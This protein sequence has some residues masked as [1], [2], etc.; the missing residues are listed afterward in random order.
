MPPPADRHRFRRTS[1]EVCFV[2]SLPRAANGTRVPPR[3]CGVQIM[4]SCSLP[5]GYLEVRFGTEFM[6]LRFCRSRNVLSLILRMSSAADEGQVK[7][8]R[9]DYSLR[10]NRTPA[11]RSPASAPNTGAGAWVK[12]G[13]GVPPSGAAVVAAGV[14]CTPEAGRRSPGV[15]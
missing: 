1:A 5:A 9:E 4:K 3:V 10:L 8:R 6:S 13:T 14:F 15:F 2:M 7:E 11:A 12:V